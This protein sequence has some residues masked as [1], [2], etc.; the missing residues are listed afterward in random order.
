MSD[1]ISYESQIEQGLIRVNDRHGSRYVQAEVLP[2]VARPIPS[3]PI[4]VD[5][6]AAHSPQIVQQV[7]KSESDPI[8][9]ARAMVLKTHLITGF[10]AMLTGASMIALQWYPQDANGLIIFLIWIGVASLEWLASFVMLA[11]LDY[12]ETPAAQAWYQMKSYVRFMGK[13]QDHRLRMM[14][15]DQ[16][17]QNG[18]RKW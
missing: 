6:Y 4:I 5:P 12:K 1:K 13:E 10:M 18:R 11:I 2:P 14:Y 15:P 7:A 17:D 16:Y 8:T 9:R 3:A